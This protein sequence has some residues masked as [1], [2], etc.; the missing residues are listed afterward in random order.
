VIDSVRRLLRSSEN[1]QV[2]SA[3]KF[4]LSSRYI[5]VLASRPEKEI[6]IGRSNFCSEGPIA[7]PVNYAQ[8]EGF[9]KR[10]G[11]SW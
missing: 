8:K 4:T 2:V 9:F 10:K 1:I 3:V 7:L 11:S 5:S 6:D